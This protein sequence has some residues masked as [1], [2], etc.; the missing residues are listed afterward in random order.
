MRSWWLADSQAD[1]LRTVRRHPQLAPLNP[2]RPDGIAP[3]TVVV[4][5]TKVIP[6]W[7]Y[8]SSVIP[9]HATQQC[10]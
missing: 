9:H 10:I 1:G 4:G 3:P 8:R 5:T 6:P 7:V 2:V